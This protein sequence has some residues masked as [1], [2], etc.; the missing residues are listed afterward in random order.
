MPTSKAGA[1]R[2]KGSLQVGSVILHPDDDAQRQSEKMSRIILDRMFHFAGLLAPDGTI[3]EINSPALEGAG[4]RIE[5]IRGT[6]FWKARWFALSQE[7]KTQQRSFIKR[8]ASGE[9]IRCDLE[10]YGE[11]SGEQTIFT[12][13]SLTP[14]RDTSGSVVFLLAEGRNITRKKEIEQEVARKNA[15]LEQLLQQVKHLDIEKNR[16]YSNLSHELRTPLTLILGPVDEMLARPE[17]LSPRQ[18]TQLASVRRNAVALLRLVNEL[19]DLAKV[20]AGKMELDYERLNIGDLAR[21]VVAHFEAHALQRNIACVVDADASLE[22][23]VDP[24]KI[25]QALFNLIANAFHATPDGGRIICTVQRTDATRW[26]LTVRDSGLGI[27]AEQRESIFERFQQGAMGAETPRQGSGLGL[28]I[29]KEVV[30]LHAGNVSAGDAPGG[31]ALFQAQFPILAPATARVRDRP[32]IQASSQRLS[33]AFPPPTSLEPPTTMSDRP[34]I[35]VVEDNY[36]MRHLICR[37]LNDEYDITSAQNGTAALKLLEKNTPDLVITDLMMPGV[38]GDEL[39]RKM[40]ENSELMQ[41]PVLVLSARADEDLRQ[42]LLSEWVQDY[43]TKPFFAPEL[44]SRVRNL[45]TMRMARSALQQELETHNS[46]IMQLTSELI[47]GRAALRFSL[48]EQ[49]KSERRWRAIHDNSAVGVAVVGLNW[50]LV[51]TNPAFCKMLGYSQDEL[52]GVHLLDITHPDDRIIT[53]KRLR[54]LTEG[55]VKQYHNQKR[56]MHKEG[57]S[58]WT[59]S[60]VSVIP[61]TQESAPLMIGIVEDIDERKR[62]EHELEQARIELARVSRFTTMG[63]LAASITH[64]INQPLAAIRANAHACQKWLELETP[65]LTEALT[66]AALIARDAQRAADVVQRIRG[67]L[68]RGEGKR[69]L[70]QLS[71]LTTAVLDFVRDTLQLNGIR[72]RFD[73]QETIPAVLADPVQLQQVILNLLL[74]AIE[75][76]Q[77]DRDERVLTLASGI[78]ADGLSVYLSVSDTGIGIREEDAQRLFD[79]FYTTKP[80]GLGMGLAICQT[81]I[82]AHGGDLHVVPKSSSEPGSTIRFTLPVTSGAYE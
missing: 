64:E 52:E 6:P 7:S 23:E 48:E 37:I 81:I 21:D 67:F 1:F 25:R 59:R 66:T 38:S 71:T 55:T 80:D 45:V 41:V 26:L 17:A 76:M 82:E 8:A 61:E 29:V 79:A 65:D 13:Y 70:V 39:V 72:V 58:V 44:R 19:L 36:E 15:E 57:R 63:E 2:V 22:V 74:N 60:S 30:G 62:A 12:D 69:E 54:Q 34:K 31:G 68:K 18:S 24:E 49:R 47:S 32:Q 46:D 10:I 53:T 78:D 33:L 40:R 73:N 27:P 3:L 14:V 28:S 50:H 9:F 5:D 51:T 43:V 75:S 4:L 20:D 16:F 56:F 77:L 42:S 11:A 35:M